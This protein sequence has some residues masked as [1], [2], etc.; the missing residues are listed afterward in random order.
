MDAGGLGLGERED[1]DVDSEEFSSNELKVENESNLRYSLS[2]EES[3][4]CDREEA[5]V[6]G[7]VIGA[8]L[9]GFDPLGN[10]DVAK[11]N[12]E[13][14]KLKAASTTAPVKVLDSGG[15][16]SYSALCSLPE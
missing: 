8:D 14:S 10:Q 15:S 4:D 7:S 13:L 11:L 1:Q 2:L 16:T 12:A 3:R 9:P 6:P 5:N